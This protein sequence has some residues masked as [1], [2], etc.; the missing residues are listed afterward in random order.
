M[1]AAHFPFSFEVALEI[2]TL[3]SY[4]EFQLLFVSS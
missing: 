1:I 4:F 2:L 3:L